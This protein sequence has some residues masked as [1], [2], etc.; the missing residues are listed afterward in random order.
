MSRYQSYLNTSVAI[1]KE[2]RGE[3]PFSEFSKLF[4]S[5]D[6]KYGSTDRKM[7][8]H[9]CYC[10]FRLGKSMMNKDTGEKIINALFLCSEGPN[11][12]LEMLNPDLHT[13]AGSSL[14]EKF[15]KLNIDYSDRI[16]PWQEELSEGIDIKQF[17][18]SFLVQPDLFLRIRPGME[19]VVTE[20]LQK[21]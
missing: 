4:F 21:S 5:K 10:Y 9:L 11:K 7:I 15:S 3:Q 14:E 6:K 18:E 13:L 1:L 20:K 8:S 16:F 12:M 2:Y 19:K 17:N